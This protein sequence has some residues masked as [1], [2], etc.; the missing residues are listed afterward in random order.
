MQPMPVRVDRDE[1]SC[2]FHLS[3]FIS[4]WEGAKQTFVSCITR[5]FGGVLMRV[6][7]RD[8][9]ASLSS[10]PGD[11]RC[12]YRMYGG[13]STM[14]LRPDSLQFAFTSLLTTDY[15]V[16]NEIVRRGV[17]VLL[18]KLG[19]YER[20]EYSLTAN[21][22]LVPLTGIA[23]AHLARFPSD[24]MVSA[25][26]N[27][28]GMQYRDPPPVLPWLEAL[29]NTESCDAQWSNPKCYPMDCL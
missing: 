24:E 9:S 8:F 23:E 14:I 12:T 15:P 19:S 28:S 4:N 3:P 13:S 5:D 11:A 2:T 7:P 29:T 16:I 25:S 22:H 21:R 26:A 27:A 18:T 1:V 6:L 10:E 20:H 17:A